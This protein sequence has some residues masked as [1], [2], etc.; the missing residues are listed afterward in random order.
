MTERHGRVEGYTSHWFE[1]KRLSRV[2][3]NDIVE[4]ETL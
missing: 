4:L 3:E 2:T 1:I